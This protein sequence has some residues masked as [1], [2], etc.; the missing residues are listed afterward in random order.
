M[1]GQSLPFP[2][3]P[4][5]DANGIIG[6]PDL[7]SLLALYGEEFS[8]AVISEDN[9]SAIMYMGDM[10]Y[11]LCAQSCRNLPGMW[12]IPNIEDLGLVW[13]DVSDVSTVTTTWLK[14]TDFS[15]VDL[16]Y[17]YSAN[18]PAEPYHAILTTDHPTRQYRC[19]CAINEIPKVE[20]SFCNS[21]GYTINTGSS[22]Q[23]GVAPFM[24]CCNEKVQQG[25]VPLGGL[26]K[27]V[28][29]DA[30]QAFWRWAE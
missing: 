12:N 11:P 7:L 8:P 25:W 18:A 24:E 28:N 14:K 15:T 6:S 21:S 22:D 5:E 17:W 20:Y 13:D 9:E 27:G 2:Y 23:N 10:D 26:A 29:S 30:G 1:L 3:N 16:P 19:Y 4:D